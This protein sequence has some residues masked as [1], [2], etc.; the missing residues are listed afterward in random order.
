M[1]RVIIALCGVMLLFIAPVVYGQEE[2]LFGTAAD[3]SLLFG[4]EF[5]LGGD[6]F[7]F[8]FEDETE[9][10][11]APAESDDFFGEFEE[12]P[13]EETADTTA[14]GDDWGFG[15]D[16]TDLITEEEYP[17][18]PLNFQK[19]VQGTFMEGSGL[20]LSLYSPQYVSDKMDTWYSFMDYSLSI[21]SPWHFEAAP[22]TVSFL[23]DISSFNFKNSFPAGGSFKGVSIMP[24]VRVELYGIEAEAGVG[25]YLPTFGVMTGLGYSVQYHSLFVSA[26]YRWNWAY[27]IAPI[28]SGWWMEP[29]LTTGIK[30]W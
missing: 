16:S 5:D 10:E 28:G 7:S 30:L 19:A 29:R 26:G 1:D 13:E 14:A 17:D 12:E 23:L 21:V 3:D 8:D 25:M 27:D 15:E 24:M 20:T 6:D 2:D 11:E 9:A 4:D 22:T 18:H